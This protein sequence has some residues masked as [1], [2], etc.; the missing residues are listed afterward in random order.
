[1]VANFEK[2]LFLI[3]SVLTF[4]LFPSSL[5]FLMCLRAKCKGC[6][7][8]CGTD[9][10]VRVWKQERDFIIHHLMVRFPNQAPLK[11]AAHWTK[12]KKENWTNNSWGNTDSFTCSWPQCKLQ[13]VWILFWTVLYCKNESLQDMK[14]LLFKRRSIYFCSNFCVFISKTVTMCTTFK[15]FLVWACVLFVNSLLHFCML[16]IGHQRS[17]KS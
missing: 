1:M 10:S 5:Y 11:T 8:C 6:C 13:P 14:L 9:L 4:F 16:N 17:C 15:T 7:Q 3:S 12:S 2:L